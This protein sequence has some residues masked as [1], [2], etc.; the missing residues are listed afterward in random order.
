MSKIIRRDVDHDHSCLFSSVAYLTDRAN[1]N[2]DS[3]KKYRNLIVDYILNNEVEESCL[4]AIDDNGFH[5]SDNN[6][7]TSVKE[8]Y[9][10]TIAKSNTW[11]GQ[12]EM[13]IFCI[14]FKIQIC[15]VDIEGNDIYV[16]G[17]PYE[18]RIYI[19]WTRTH[20]DPLVMND[21]ESADSL[22]DVTK[23]KSNDFDVFNKVKDFLKN[24]KEPE[25]KP[26]KC[27]KEE[28]E[29]MHLECK[30]CEE[31]FLGKSKAIEHA[32][33]VDHWGFRRI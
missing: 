29:K 10:E 5:P 17:G 21:C 24:M 23:F 2:E 14:I 16:I 11:G 7:A 18:Y 32:N 20:Y 33:E 15:V 4:M 1:Y 30:T 6:D 9:I 8:K 27:T 13:E 3:A 19:I 12:N 28:D 26:Q 31:K 22:T 25:E